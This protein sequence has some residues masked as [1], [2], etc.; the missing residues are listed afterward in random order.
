MT[1]ELDELIRDLFS[2]Q[3]PTH[4]LVETQSFNGPAGACV[5]LGSLL[6]AGKRYYL[7]ASED[8]HVSTEANA[9]DTSAD[10]TDFWIPAGWPWPFQ[11]K[12]G[13]LGISLLGRVV[14]G[15]VWVF[16]AKSLTVSG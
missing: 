6:T 11:P 13:A 3:L 14:A 16:Q 15:D 9:V 12:A 7:I 2:A 1:R 4:G 10:A 8:V 5:N